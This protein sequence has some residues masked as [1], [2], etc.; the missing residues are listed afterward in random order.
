[1]TEYTKPLPAVT[2][3]NEPFWEACRRHEL[4]LPR[5]R[6]CAHL[7]LPGPICPKCLSME[8]DWE[9]VSGRGA[10]YTWTVIYQRYH[11][12]FAEELPYNVAMVELEEGPRLISNVTGCDNGDLRVGMA[13]EVVFDDVTDEV[14]LPRFKP[15]A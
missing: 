3:D 15:T 4:Q 8:A 7:R 13:L 1:L 10:L 14:T 9:T 12:G 2:P 11:A 6:D 5:C